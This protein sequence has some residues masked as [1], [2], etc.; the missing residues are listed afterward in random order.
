MSQTP[1]ALPNYLRRGDVAR[2]I[3]PMGIDMK[4]FQKLVD[5]GKIQKIML[6]E[7]GRGY[8]L[9]DEIDQVIIKPFREAELRAGLT[10][11]RI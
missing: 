8:F 6:T 11:G 7:R 10:N 2:W 9:R 1:N 5:A 3:E 4:V